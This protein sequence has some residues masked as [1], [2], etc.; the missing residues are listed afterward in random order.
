MC[1][2]PRVIRLVG[3]LNRSQWAIPFDYQRPSRS[4]L[5]TVESYSP[6]VNVSPQSNQIQTCRLRRVTDLIAIL[7]RPLSATPLIRQTPV[8]S[9][10]KQVAHLTP[11]QLCRLSE[12]VSSIL[13]RQQATTL[14]LRPVVS[15]LMRRS[16]KSRRR[17]QCWI[18]HLK[19][20]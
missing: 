4:A 7:T 12:R 5:Q 3:S 8:A 10:R 11:D 17:I 15:D 16:V 2:L 20:A 9:H 19:M 18:P 14:L 1:H 6:R 13:S